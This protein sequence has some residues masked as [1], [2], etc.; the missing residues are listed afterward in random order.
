MSSM[1]FRIYFKARLELA[2]FGQTVCGLIKK[3]EFIPPRDAR[4]HNKT[5]DKGETTFILYPIVP[6]KTEPP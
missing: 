6:L 4:Q 1:I 3:D 2:P 5:K